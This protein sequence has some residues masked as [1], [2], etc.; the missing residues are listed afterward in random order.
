M[1]VCAVGGITGVKAIANTRRDRQSGFWL[2]IAGTIL[3]LI[4]VAL[5]VFVLYLAFTFAGDSD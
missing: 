3:S 1:P 2:G 4:W 5:I